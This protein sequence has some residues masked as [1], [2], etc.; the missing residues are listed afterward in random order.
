LIHDVIILWTY[1]CIWAGLLAQDTCDQWQGDYNPTYVAKPI[2]S[3]TICTY[4]GE[5]I[6][7]SNLKNEEI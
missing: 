5:L 6:P 2:T 7:S 3:S 1:E 4:E